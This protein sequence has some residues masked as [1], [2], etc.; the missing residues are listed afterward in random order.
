MA[1]DADTALRHWEKGTP[2]VPAVPFANCPIATTLGVMGKK[3]T[4]LIIRDVSMRK[5]ERFSELLRSIPGITPRVLS[6]R[7][8]ELEK[9]GMIARIVE[10]KSPRFVRWNLTEKGWDVL[11]VLMS[12]VA[13]GSKWLSPTVFADGEPREI[14]EIYPQDNLRSTYVNLDV[15]KVRIRD[16]HRSGTGIAGS[17]TG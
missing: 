16:L 15:D 14:K 13:F 7:L 8:R 11:P 9:A 5:Q 6:M 12:Y 4:M 1:S 3:W 2:I 10:H 17:W